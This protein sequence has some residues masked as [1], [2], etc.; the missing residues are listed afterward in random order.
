MHTV[1]TKGGFRKATFTIENRSLP[2][3]PKT[4]HLA[5]MSILGTLKRISSR[6][7]LES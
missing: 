6:W 2:G 4:I 7:K 5:A 3:N 1:E